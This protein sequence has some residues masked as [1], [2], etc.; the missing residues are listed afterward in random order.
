MSTE[1]GRPPGLAGG[2]SGSSKPYCASVSACP[3]P[4]SPTRA[5]SIGVDMAGLQEG[6]DPVQQPSK[7]SYFAAQTAIGSLF[8][9]AVRADSLDHMPIPAVNAL[10]HKLMD[11]EA[12][13]Q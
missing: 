1:R 2:M 5:R 4:K 3:A 6:I 7:L 10:R 12:Y 13:Y 8:K 11:G 9:Q